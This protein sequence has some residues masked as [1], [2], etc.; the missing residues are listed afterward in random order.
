MSASALDARPAR[1][2]N[3]FAAWLRKRAGL[4]LVFLAIALFWEYA[5]KIFGIKE[6][7]LPPPTK[8]ASE[9]ARRYPAVMQGAWVTTQEILGGYLLAVA[10]SLVT[11]AFGLGQP[12][13]SAAVGDAVHLDVR[14]VALGV[15]T[16][17]FLVG[18]SVGSAVVAG[19]G[20]VLGVPESLGVLA[21]LPLL[22]LVAL[23]PELRRSRVRD[24]EP[25]LI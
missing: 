13:M 6:Y 17:L 7:L 11:V 1:A 23:V 12:A 14:G 9:F 10:V 4:I 2:P 15:A 16:L 3:A 19:L 24:P 25:E 18:G 8:I 21:V 5:V 22:G 20:D